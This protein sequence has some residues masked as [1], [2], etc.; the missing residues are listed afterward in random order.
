MGT[1]AFSYR[2][3]PIGNRRTAT[4]NSAVSEYLANCLNQYSQITNNGALIT[5]QYDLDGNM[6]SYGEWRF[7]WDAEN[8][9]VMA[10]N[11]TTVVSNSYDYMSR[12][13]AKAVNG[14][15]TAFTYQGWAMFKETTSSSTNSYVYGLDLSGTPQGAGTIGG[16]LCA[17]LNGSTAFYAYDANGNVTDLVGTNG[18]FA[19]KYQYDPYGN[20]IAKS[21]DLADA[22]PFRFSTKYLDSETGLLYYG[23][24]QYSPELGR[25]LSRDPIGERGGMNLYGF[26][27]NS[28]LCF[29]DPF[30]LAVHLS[31]LNGEAENH[32]ASATA[33]I[34]GD[35]SVL[36]F[37][38][39]SSTAVAYPWSEF[40]RLWLIS[41]YAVAGWSCTETIGSGT[42]SLGPGKGMVAEWT[43][44][45]TRIVDSDFLNG[46]T[47]TV[48]EDDKC[49]KKATL[50]VK[51]GWNVLHI[52]DCPSGIDG[53]Y[54]KK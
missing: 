6:T 27:G 11:A 32:S 26:G 39:G 54:Y 23:Y 14:Q 15:A 31:P 30:G 46:A 43:S 7:A 10:S 45:A 41:D 51:I 48:Y 2:Y 9:L 29:I 33:T 16:I 25:W 1:N 37:T 4:N 42:H 34:Q 28:P 20:T 18:S 5:P 40:G 53:V 22:N 19:S 35:W 21:G 8:R 47:K 17:S 12:R 49:C 13:V 38:K 3:D 44:G 52:Y 50:P 36:T 24:R